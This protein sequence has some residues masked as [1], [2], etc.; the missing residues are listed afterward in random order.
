V[1]LPPKS[2]EWLAQQPE[3]VLSTTEAQKHTLQTKHTLPRPQIMNSADQITDIR[4][5][6]ESLA[7]SMTPAICDELSEAV[8][9]YW[10]VMPEAPEEGE[11]PEEF[12]TIMLYDS[13]AKIVSRITN[14]LLV[15][16]PLC[17][18]NFTSLSCERSLLKLIC[19]PGRNIYQKYGRLCV[20][21]WTLEHHLTLLAGILSICIS[22]L[23]YVGNSQ[24]C[25]GV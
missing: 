15:G 21:Y 3:S 2:A 1:L 4:S 13:F 16:Q 5:E 8:C 17:K 19:R 22:S 18:D 10:G 23:G 24:Q 11:A 25:Q 6:L 12:K 20:W 7:S 14:R 9:D